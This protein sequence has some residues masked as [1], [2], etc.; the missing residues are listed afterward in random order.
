MASASPAYHDAQLDSLKFQL[1]FPA[2][3]YPQLEI[4]RMTGALELDIEHVGKDD[5]FV[6]T[7]LNG[8]TPAEAA[9]ALV[10]GSKLADVAVRKQ[11]LEGGEAAD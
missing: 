4:A 1:L 11:L 8:K 5:P 9:A 6:K 3:V 10:N 2:P 7:V